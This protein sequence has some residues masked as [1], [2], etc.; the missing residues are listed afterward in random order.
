MSP[1]FTLVW[2]RFLPLSWRRPQSHWA[3]QI[4]SRKVS[5][6]LPTSCTGTAP[7]TEAAGGAAVWIEDPRDI[8]QAADRVI[9][10]LRDSS[11]RR[12]QRQRAGYV[13]AGRFSRHQMAAKYRELYASL[14]GS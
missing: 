8:E 2:S 3:R 9:E 10:V 14:L 12:R 7:L 4:S 5:V 1:P 13:N 11:G 6:P